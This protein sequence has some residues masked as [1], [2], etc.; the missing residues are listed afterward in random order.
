MMTTNSNVDALINVVRAFTDESIPH[1]EGSVDVERDIATIDLELAFSDLALLERRLQRID[2]SLKG[3]KQLERQGL[4][5][6]QEMLMK[7][8]ADLEKDM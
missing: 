3:A 2:I 4:L 5:R 8:K 7:V 6:E 1:I